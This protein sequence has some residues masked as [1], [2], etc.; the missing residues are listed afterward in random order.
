M[1]PEKKSLNFIFPTKHVIPKSLKFSNWLS[2]PFFSITP[3]FQ[4][5]FV[6]EIFRSRVASAAP[7]FVTQPGPP[8]QAIRAS[9]PFPL[10]RYPG[11]HVLLPQ[12]CSEKIRRKNRVKIGFLSAR[13][14]KPWPFYPRS[15]EVTN[16]L[17]KRSQRIARWWWFFQKHL[18]RRGLWR[19]AAFSVAGLRGI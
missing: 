5:L 12:L 1:D 17:S 19:T 6:G 15:L 13:W 16:N 7:S 2:Q 11:H 8:L 3:S 18:K 9:S 10:P 4:H 14:F